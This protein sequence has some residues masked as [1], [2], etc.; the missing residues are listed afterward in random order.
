MKK[1]SSPNSPGESGRS[2]RTNSAKKNRDPFARPPHPLGYRFL[3]D[4]RPIRASRFG[5]IIPS[6]MAKYGLGRRI[7]VER[8]HEAWRGALE[9]V[10]G[11]PTDEF[12]PELDGGASDK[13]QT[14]LQYARPVSFRS[15]TLRVE[16]ASNLLYQELQFYLSQILQEIRRRLPDENIQSIKLIVR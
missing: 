9:T 13:L 8:F 3:S 10:F 12:A 11:G 4:E 16:I 14:Y 5:A 2:K 6:V 15:G 7:G 1:P